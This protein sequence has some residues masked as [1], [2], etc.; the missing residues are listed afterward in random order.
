MVAEPVGAVVAP[1]VVILVD[2]FLHGADRILPDGAVI[3]AAS[4]HEAA[5]GEPHERGL[6]GSQ[7]FHQVRA[8]AVFPAFPRF[9]R[10]QRHHVEVKLGGGIRADLQHGFAAGLVRREADGILFPRTA[11]DGDR[12]RCKLCSICIRKRRLQVRFPL[13]P[14][15]KGQVVDVAA[16]DRDVA[17][18]AAVEVADKPTVDDEASGLRFYLEGGRIVL[19]QRL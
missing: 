3:D 13:D 8:Q 12:S 9:L 11:L 1:V 7:T 5:A 15:I 6:H 10:E 16:R 17:G 4:F 18:R 2:A 14:G 19:I